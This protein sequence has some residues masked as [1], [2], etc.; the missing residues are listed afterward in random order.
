MKFIEEISK[1]GVS[2]LLP[3]YKDEFGNITEIIDKSGETYTAYK[4]LKTVLK[5]IC[6]YYGVDIKSV[7]QKYSKI[8]NRKNIIPLP[9]SQDLILIPFKMRKPIFLK[10]G[11]YGYINIF[12]IENIYSKKGNTIIKLY[13]EKEITCISKLKTAREHY[14]NGK[15]I[16]NDISFKS[17]YNPVLDINYLYEE[18]NSPATKGDIA[19]LKKEIKEI[20]ETL[21]Q[22]EIK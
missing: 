22:A 9:L 16:L 10:D 2:C 18:L 8:I 21:K 11:S 14:N 5:L 17:Q 7:R 19:V 15:A 12:S 6:K 1:K 3:I 4:T 13:N 20:K